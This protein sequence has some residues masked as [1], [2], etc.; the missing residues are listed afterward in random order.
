MSFLSLSFQIHPLYELTYLYLLPGFPEFAV[1][2]FS[3]IE[4][5]VIYYAR[6]VR[7]I[8]VSH[9]YSLLEVFYSRELFE[10]NCFSRGSFL[11]LYELTYLNLLPGLLRRMSFPVSFCGGLPFLFM[12]ITIRMGVSV[13]SNVIDYYDV[14]SLCLI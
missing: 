13:C 1:F 3:L 12:R 5:L 6:D 11:P 14:D 9:A 2:L 10:Y 7:S 4:G 8:A